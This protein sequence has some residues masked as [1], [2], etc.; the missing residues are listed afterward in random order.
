MSFGTA[1]LIFTIPGAGTGTYDEL[2]G[3]ILGEPSTVSATGCRHRPLKPT[4]T[5]EFITQVATQPW[6]STIPI[7]E[8]DSELQASLI[9]AAKA[10][11]SFTVDG[12][13]YQILGG[14][15]PFDD[16]AAPFKMT[17]FSKR[18]DA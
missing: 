18:E 2:G 14:A 12:I 11:G 8:Y 9:D 15:M 7:G 4:E 3:E 10:T 13:A 6:K 1:I 5:P 16:M 17:I